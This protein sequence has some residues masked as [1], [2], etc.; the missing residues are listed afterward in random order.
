MTLEELEAKYGSGMVYDTGQ[1]QEFFSV[2]AFSAP[3]VIVTRK[4]DN[5]RGSM[6]FQNMPRFYFDFRPA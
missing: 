1:L 6:E 3:M 5:Q 2:E 4:S